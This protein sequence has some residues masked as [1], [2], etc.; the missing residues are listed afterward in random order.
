M[1]EIQVAVRDHICPSCSPD[2][3]LSTGSM[4][5]SFTRAD[6]RSSTRNRTKK[7]KWHRLIWFQPKA[8]KFAFPSWLELLN[9]QAVY[10]R[11]NRQSGS[12]L[13]NQLKKKTT[14]ISVEAGERETERILFNINK[15][16]NI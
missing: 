11:Q 9:K 7:V 8:P 15:S 10:P 3:V 2:R 16:N 4:F 5:G 6:D 12:S 1:V 13:A 14:F